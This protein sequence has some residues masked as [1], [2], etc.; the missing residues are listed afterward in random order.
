MKR[1]ERVAAC[2]MFEYVK[3]MNVCHAAWRDMAEEFV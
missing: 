1:N 3:Y 2:I